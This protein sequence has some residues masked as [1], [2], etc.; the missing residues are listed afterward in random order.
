MQAAAALG[1]EWSE[2]GCGKYSCCECRLVCYRNAFLIQATTAD[3]ELAPGHDWQGALYGTCY[4]CFR[5][6]GPWQGKDGF[7]GVAGSEQDHVK[8]FTKMARE[9]HSKRADVK[10]RDVARLRS[11]RFEAL[12]EEEMQTHGANKKLRAKLWSVT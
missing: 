2:E 12:L 3:G 11:G 10:S 5:G 7:A 4:K 1:A 8:R 6:Q 9:R